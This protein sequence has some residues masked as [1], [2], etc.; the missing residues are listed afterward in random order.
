MVLS[1]LGTTARL[2]HDTVT[3]DEIARI[4]SQ[5]TGIPV[6]KLL[7]GEMKKLLTLQSEL[8]KRVVGQ[9]EATRVVAEAIQRSRAGCDLFVF[10]GT[11]ILIML[12]SSL[13]F[14]RSP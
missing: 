9:E 5:W 2:I 7:Q 12:C 1:P 10:V 14:V 3:E 6:S 8:N 4:V 13:R 11:V